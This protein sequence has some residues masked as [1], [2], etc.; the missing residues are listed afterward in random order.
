M[1]IA[2]STNAYARQELDAAVRRGPVV[3]R[4]RMQTPCALPRG[5]RRPIGRDT[6][7]R[8]TEPL[9]LSISHPQ[10]TGKGAVP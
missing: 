5:G 7:A 4:G 9:S 10:A 6:A 1:R 3:G 2:Y 8:L